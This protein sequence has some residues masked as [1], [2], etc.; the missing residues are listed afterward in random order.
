[1]EWQIKSQRR[2]DLDFTVTVG[3][4][5]WC[6]FQF[7]KAGSFR[8]GAGPPQ[9]NTGKR[10]LVLEDIYECHENEDNRYRS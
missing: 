5:L 3:V 4:D 2:G 10:L 1:M 6:W 8:R 7:Q 9:K